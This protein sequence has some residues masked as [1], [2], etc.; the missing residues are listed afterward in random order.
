MQSIKATLPLITLASVSKK[1][2]TYSFG[3]RRE[4][5]LNL[6]VR[7]GDA[8]FS[9][10]CSPSNTHFSSVIQDADGVLFHSS[11]V[12]SNFHRYYLFDL[13][14]HFTQRK[15]SR[16]FIFSFA[17]VSAAFVAFSSRAHW[18]PSTLKSCFL[19]A[20]D[21]TCID[22][23]TY[24][25][26]GGS[27]VESLTLVHRC[28]NLSNRCFRKFLVA[29]R[30]YWP[31]G[32]RGG[33]PSRNQWENER[34]E[35]WSSRSIRPSLD[36]FQ[37]WSLAEARTGLSR[38]EN[39][40]SGREFLAERALSPQASSYSRHRVRRWPVENP[41]GL[42]HESRWSLHVLNCSTEHSDREFAWNL[43]SARL[44]DQLE[45]S[46]DWL[47]YEDER[48]ARTNSI[49]R[50]WRKRFAPRRRTDCRKTAR[51]TTGTKWARRMNDRHW[52]TE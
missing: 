43:D 37:H 33:S 15:V 23:E 13:L 18:P 29:I 27:F 39:R 26:N 19:F 8:P 34:D 49:A 32:R 20:R 2:P 46:V 16:W 36:L 25:D 11:M 21:R 12:S 44:P 35:I 22:R 47:Q 14:V 52:H 1:P 41:D 7:G 51:W 31:V 17:V 40:T 24:S 48:L 42:N 50:T 9:A 30:W 45:A 28:W 10:K 38:W 6:T 5:Q 4:K 3:W